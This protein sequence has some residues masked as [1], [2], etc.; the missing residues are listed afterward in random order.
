MIASVVVDCKINTVNRTFDYLVPLCFKTTIAKGQRVYVPFGKQN[1]LGIVVDLKEDSSVTGLKE[2]YDIL[3][4]VPC[5]ND[6]LIELAKN[7]HQYYF[8]LYI[9]CLLTMIP[10]A[11][12]VKYEKEFLVLNDALLPKEIAHLFKE[13]KLV[14]QTK[15]KEYL[16]LLQKLCKEKVL[17]LVNNISDKAHIK[18]ENYISV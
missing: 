6:E 9:T 14:Y 13:G 18:E 4:L 17:S 7:M 8:S 11:L 16:P 12:R 5:L 15:H 1:L 3:D 2:I 10:A